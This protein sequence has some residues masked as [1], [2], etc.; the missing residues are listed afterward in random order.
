MFDGII[1]FFILYFIKV[2]INFKASVF[3][4]LF[5]K[6]QA[7]PAKETVFVQHIS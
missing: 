2:K 5:L 1:Y 6:L 3:V 7:N 4:A